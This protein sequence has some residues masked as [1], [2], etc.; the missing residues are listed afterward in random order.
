MSAGKGPTVG[1]FVTQMKMVLS[2]GSYATNITAPSRRQ[3]ERSREIVL[4]RLGLERL[5]GPAER[6]GIGPEWAEL[7]NE[8]PVVL[9]RKGNLLAFSP[10][11]Q[12]GAIKHARRRAYDLMETA[13]TGGHNR[14]L[15]KGPAC[16]P[17]PDHVRAYVATQGIDPEALAVLIYLLRHLE[18]R[19]R[20]NRY[21]L[22]RRWTPEIR[23]RIDDREGG[24]QHL[25]YDMT[26]SHH[27]IGDV[28]I[29]IPGQPQIR[30]VKHGISVKQVLPRSI[31][32]GL[33]GKPLSALVDIPGLA[34]ET[35]ASTKMIGPNVSHAMLA[36]KSVDG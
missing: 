3:M 8:I 28:Q 30:I 19:N 25:I 2:L 16:A 23:R 20:G 13:L 35:I 15:L 11:A 34:N 32:A 12:K 33:E 1:S 36:K 4:G 18:F 10:M 14:T 31:L 24:N 22:S 17:L 26:P 7:S 9:D 27:D 21:K 6:I 5:V 29:T